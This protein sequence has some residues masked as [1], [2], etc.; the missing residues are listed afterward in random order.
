MWY[1]T[2]SLGQICL[3]EMLP[4]GDAFWHIIVSLCTCRVVIIHVLVSTMNHT[5]WIIHTFGTTMLLLR[6]FIVPIHVSVR[7]SI[8][9]WMRE[10]YGLFK[11]CGEK[12]SLRNKNTKFDTCGITL[13]STADEANLHGMHYIATLNWVGHLR[14]ERSGHCNLPFKHTL[15]K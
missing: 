9:V 2:A 4:I 11:T 3:A 12:A 5:E 10:R 8:T 14:T 13:L 15:A 1:S 7:Q 6:E